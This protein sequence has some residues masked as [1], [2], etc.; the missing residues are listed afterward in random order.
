M[1]QPYWGARGLRFCES[2]ISIYVQA[3]NQKL[4][5]W[6]NRKPV[7]FDV[8]GVLRRILLTPLLLGDRLSG[9]N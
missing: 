6:S 3:I 2:S 5:P 1:A 8:K 4:Q 7:P 9:Q